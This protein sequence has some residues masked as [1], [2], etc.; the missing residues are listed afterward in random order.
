MSFVIRST[1][2]FFIANTKLRGCWIRLKKISTEGKI[3]F[4]NHYFCTLIMPK[5]LKH[6][7]PED[8]KQRIDRN[9]HVLTEYFSPEFVKTLNENVLQHIINPTYFRPVFVN[10]DEKIERNNPKHPVILASNHSGMAFPWD[11]IVFGCDM[12]K[13]YEYDMSKLFRPLASPMLSKTALMQPFM[14]HNCWRMCGGV[15]ATSINF[16]TLMH[17]PEGNVLIYPEGVPGI[18]KGFNNKYKLQRFATSFIRMSIKYQTDIVPF[19][20]VNAEY[21]HPYS[22]SVGWINKLSQKIGIPFLPLSPLFVCMLFQPWLFYLSFPAKMTYVK[23]R[24]LKPYEMTN[25]KSYEELSDAEIIKIRDSIKQS[26][27]EDLDE[28]V[29]EYGHT[30]IGWKDFFKQ[31][32]KNRKFFP[33]YYPFMWPFLF[34][35]FDR[36][37]KAQEIKDGS[38]VDMKITPLVWVKWLFRNPIIICYYL[39]IIGWIPLL[40][41]GYSKQKKQ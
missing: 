35:E 36:Q 27:Q 6:L 15:D 22:Y 28:A 16:E 2:L 41:K 13:Y 12:Y 40:L 34:T 9:Q 10:F 37:W 17:L 18:G 38:G 1:C 33:Y 24:R 30:P 21:V 32:W 8:L 11:A 25:G 14:I 23:G 4:E 3:D 20:T 31:S 7:S 39:P 26:F 19:S 5:S 29:K